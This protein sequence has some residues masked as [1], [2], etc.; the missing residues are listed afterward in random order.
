MIVVT[1]VTTVLIVVST[2]TR[3]VIDNCCSVTAK[4]N[5]FA[6]KRPSTGIY[7]PSG[8][9]ALQPHHDI[10]HKDIV[11]NQCNK[12]TNLSQY[13]YMCFNGMCSPT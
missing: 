10:Q 9:P 11:S 2:A 13:R 3:V 1:I 12:D 5:Y 7:T 4:G 6:T 8:T